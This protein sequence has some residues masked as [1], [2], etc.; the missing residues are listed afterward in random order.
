MG[1]TKKEFSDIIIS[2]GVTND[3]SLINKLF[4]LF[5]EDSSGDL[6]YEE[7]A[8]GVE[9]FRNS[10]LEDKLKAFFDLCDIDKSGTISRY[11]FEMLLLKNLVNNDEKEK[12]R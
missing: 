6:R 3:Q 10:S 1:V 11:E 9:M 2:Y 4:W 5:D 12:Y 7:L 8:F